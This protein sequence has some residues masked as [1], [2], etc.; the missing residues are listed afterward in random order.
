METFVRHKGRGCLGCVWRHW[1]WVPTR[2]TPT[3]SDGPA[4]D[5]AVGSRWVA[6]GI[7][8]LET[9]P[10]VGGRRGRFQVGCLGVWF[11]TGRRVHRPG[12]P[13]T[14]GGLRARRAGLRRRPYEELDTAGGSLVGLPGGAGGER[15][16]QVACSLGHMAAW[17]VR[18]PTANGLASRPE[19][20]G[21]RRGPYTRGDARCAEDGRVG[22]PPLRKR[23]R[24]RWG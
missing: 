22:D 3:R 20:A 8:R 21:Q 5:G 7:G 15:G 9:G 4:N 1:P 23:G 6:G 2:G 10:D 24:G 17:D 13:R 14:G 11:D 18:W 19:E 12:S 16:S